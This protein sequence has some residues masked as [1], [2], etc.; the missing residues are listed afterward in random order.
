MKL[1]KE[2]AELTAGIDALYRRTP[3][4]DG[5]LDKEG[6][7]PVAVADVTPSSLRDYSEATAALLALRSRLSAEAESPLRRDYLEEMIDSLLALIETFEERP[8][9]FADRIRR[10][11]RVDTQMIGD[12]ILDGY[13]TT[14]RQALDELGFAGGP[15]ADD[16]VRWETSAQ[17]PA[18]AVLATMRELTLEARTRASASMYPMDDQWM[19]P[20]GVNNVPFSAYCDYPSRK[21]LMN[22]DFAYTGFGL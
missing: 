11:I 8:I 9:T 15:L 4:S 19:E 6:L 2:L 16:L 20:V 7:I 13:R 18:D 22:L 3:R 10:Q 1:G 14:I 21:V 12:E 5:F 17:V